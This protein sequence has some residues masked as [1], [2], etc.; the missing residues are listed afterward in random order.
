MSVCLRIP[1]KTDRACSCGLEEVCFYK[2]IF[3]SG[4]S[5]LVHPFVRELLSLLNLVP[6]SWRTV[7]CCM[8]LW[9][10]AN[11]DDIIRVDK[12]IH[13]FCLRSSTHSGY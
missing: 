11:D 8:V 7:I 10:S 1:L 4:L 6:N 5:F 12:F 2:A 3:N 13:L 9:L